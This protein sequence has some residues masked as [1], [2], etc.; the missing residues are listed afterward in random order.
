MKNNDLCGICEK[1]KVFAKCLGCERLLCEQCA[2]FELI[3]S[4]CGCVWPVYYCSTCAHDP[5]INPNAIFR[6]PEK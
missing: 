4:G 6:E 1:E 2:L 5:M 3:G